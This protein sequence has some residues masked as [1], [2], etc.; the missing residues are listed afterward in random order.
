MY[1]S[2]ETVQ[3][4]CAAN[5]IVDVIGQAVKLKRK[6]SSYFGLC[7]FHNEKTP[8]FSVSPGKQI[9]YCFGCGAGGDV[10]SFVMNY[11]NMTFPE[12]VKS[13]ADRVGYN[14]PEVSLSEEGRAKKKEKDRILAILKDAASFY[15]KLLRS[16]AG[17]NGM[18]Y[19]KKRGIGDNIMQ[20]FGLG[21]AGKKSEVT[22]FLKEKG[23]SDNEINA[24]GLVYIDETRGMRDRFFNRVIFPI[25]DVNNHVIGFG[26]RVMGDGEPKYLNSPETA[27]FDKGKNLYGLNAARRSRKGY[28]IACEGY[29]DV[30]SMHQ[31]GF[32]EA[33]ASLGTAFTPDHARVLKRYTEDVRLA[34][35]SDGAGVKAALR[36]IPILRD[37]GIRTRVINLKPCKDP[38]EFIKKFGKDEFS[39]RVEEAEQSLCFE[40]HVMEKNHDLSDPEGRTRFQQEMAKRLSVI[41]DEIERNNYTEAFAAEYM[42]DSDMLKRAVEQIRLM[43]DTSALNSSTSHPPGSSEVKRNTDKASSGMAG[44]QKILLT[45]MCEEPDKVYKAVKQYLDPEDFSPG[46]IGTCAELLYK[47]LDEGGPKISAIVNHF[48]DPEEQRQAAEIFSAPI[49]PFISNKDKENV[50]TDLV[51]KIKKDSLKRIAMEEDEDPISRTLRE[52]RV[53]EKLEKVR[54]TLE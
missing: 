38:D 40:I 25:M 51:I 41:K 54:I 50:I 10:V 20:S 17:E 39:K 31:A 30:I 15:F 13:L 1:Y 18:A 2:E 11:E 8:S 44:S 43:G 3:E 29:M 14:L 9:F 35:D 4:V 26:G 33:V 27:I 22:A 6:G 42:M 5:D 28:M 32:T 47:Q 23:Y 52:K 16:P 48:E 37:A 7:P 46:M 21:Y 12:A 19:F 49:D 24:A 53:L 34:Y 45:L 36:A